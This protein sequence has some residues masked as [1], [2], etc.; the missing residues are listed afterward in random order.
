MSALLGFVL[1]GVELIGTYMLWAL[2]TFA[3]AILAVV[4]AAYSA[5]IA[6]LPSMGSAP[7]IDG[8]SWINYLNFFYPLGDALT[9]FGVL[10]TMFISFLAVRYV[11]K[12]VRGL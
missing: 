11:L 8:G 9:G 7:H 4:V 5:A 12:L 6:L 1:D 3:N 2:E 10:I